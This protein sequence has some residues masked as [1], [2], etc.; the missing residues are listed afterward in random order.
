MRQEGCKVL[1]K[2][3][4]LTDLPEVEETAGCKPRGPIL[5]DVADHWTGKVEGPS[6]L[7][8]VRSACYAGV[9]ERRVVLQTWVD[10]VWSREAFPDHGSGVR[11]R[12]P[13][14]PGDREGEVT[15]ES[16]LRRRSRDGGISP[17]RASI[18]G[19]HPRS[20]E[21]G[22]RHGVLGEFDLGR[23]CDTL[24]VYLEGGADRRQGCQRLD[25][26]EVLAGRT[27]PIP[28]STGPLKRVQWRGPLDPSCPTEG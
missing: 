3:S 10:E 16:G 2:S 4:L 21:P 27:M 22:A 28:L 5:V 6:A 8:L 25:R 15:T 11:E 1:T 17:R 18:D 14:S 13:S 19:R 20:G 9:L 12:G 24:R 26:V 7:P 23:S